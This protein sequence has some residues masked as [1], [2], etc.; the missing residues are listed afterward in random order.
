MKLVEK[1]REG[2]KIHRKYDEPKTAYQR[3]IASKNIS[4]AAK[5]KL[6]RQY[7]SLNVA[8]LHRQIE[9]LKDRLFKLIEG[10]HKVEPAKAKH[11]GPDIKLNSRAHARWMKQMLGKKEK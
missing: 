4:K 5:T 8:E 1:I 3:V 9:A 2:G 10:K 11:R 7:E 6:K